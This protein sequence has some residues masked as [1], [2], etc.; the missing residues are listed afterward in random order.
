MKNKHLK[1]LPAAVAEMANIPITGN[2]VPPIWFKTITFENGK[3][4][5]NSILIL[6]D[7]AYWYRPAILRDERTGSIIGQKKKFAEDMLRR[8]YSDLEEQFGLSKKQCRDS[9]IR[10]E[11]LGV[12]RRVLRN[13]NTSTGMR[14]NILYIDLV[15]S[16]LQKLTDL[17]TQA[18]DMFEEDTPSNFKVTSPLH[19]SYQ[20]GDIEVTR[21]VPQKSLGGDIDVTTIKE[22]RLPSEI[23]SKN[24][25][26]S[27]GDSRADYFFEPKKTERENFSNSKKMVKIWNELLPSKST[28]A[29]SYLLSKLELALREQL[30]ADLD[31]WKTV[32]ENFRSSKF[33]MGEVENQRITPTLS[34]L[35]DSKE[36]RIFRV[37][38]KQHYTFGDRVIVSPHAQEIKTLE[39]KNNHLLTRQL[40]DEKKEA[41]KRFVS[42]KVNALSH[43]ELANYKAQYETF[44][45]EKGEESPLPQE[46]RAG[47]M[48]QFMFELFL[49]KQVKESLSENC[50]DFSAFVK[51]E[52]E[53][54][55]RKAELQALYDRGVLAV[56]KF[57]NGS[58]GM[59]PEK[60]RAMQ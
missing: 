39:V 28:N 9:L 16:V 57:R 51:K 21:L 26:L 1:P 42:E 11:N 48:A 6:S 20:G 43:E 5:T 18:F 49:Q 32:C 60:Q 12:I 4:D 53:L 34:W 59:F 33:L 55:E 8:S 14:N 24:S 3:P 25:P 50:I 46:G 13:I 31:A 54:K 7:I 44:M 2:I 30:G 36:P 29:N 45:T 38:E 52:A 10:L 41:E 27:S 58:A 47:R 56:S 17:S 23:S 40:E 15:P 35:V 19:Q 22:H 37:L